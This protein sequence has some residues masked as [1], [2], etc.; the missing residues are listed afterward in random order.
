MDPPVAPGS[1]VYPVFTE[2]NP[3]GNLAATVSE[4]ADP[5]VGPSQEA[6]AVSTTAETLPRVGDP[7]PEFRLPATRGR[8]VSSA[9]FRGS[10]SVVLYFYP[11]DDTPDC[12]SQARSFEGLR[13]LFAE[14]GAEILGVSPDSVRSHV[15]FARKYQLDFPLLSDADHAVAERYGVWQHIR[16]LGKEREGI[17]RTTFVIG[18]DGRIRAVYPNVNV[19]GHAE[20]VLA[21][22]D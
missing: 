4:C 6:P 18:R 7:A 13:K 11:Q 2:R 10:R 8:V 9:D 20:R 5:P 1:L 19:V 12:T 21:D 16:F 14:R 15:R 3:A 17:A 22:L